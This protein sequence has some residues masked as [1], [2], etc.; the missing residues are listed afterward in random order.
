[1][2]NE[3]HLTRVY[4]APR[5]LVWKVWTDPAHVAHWWG[6][7]GFS[8][9]HH[10]KDLRVVGTWV[11]TMH[12]PDGVDYPNVATYHE[13]IEGEK[14]VYDHGSDGQSKPLFQVTVTFIDVP[15]GTQMDMT[16]KFENEEIAKNMAGFI[17]KAGG[18]GTWDRLAEY[19]EKET[20]GQDCFV[21]H[22]SFAAPR[23][24]LFKLWTDPKHLAAWLPPVGATMEYLE[25]DIR[26]GGASFY[27]MDH[28][29]GVLY[30][31]AQYHEIQ[32]PELLTYTQMFSDENKGPG[33]HPMMPVFPDK[34]HTTV[35]FAEEGSTQTRVSVTWRPE[36]DVS[37]DE[38][39]AFLKARDGMTMGWTGS[40]DKLEG[41]MDSLETANA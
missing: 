13:V 31:K 27:R 3:L 36:G 38:L 11:Y 24:L 37:A 19:L 33:R 17:R 2:S 29:G 6:P 5:S 15:G 25:V 21:I 34:M 40:F 39:A 32:A 8:L 23:D 20:G 41:H 22:R 26:P 30:G 28:P 14:M 9:T 10:S 16:M 12:G 1:M 35:Q 7:R 4:R 18:N